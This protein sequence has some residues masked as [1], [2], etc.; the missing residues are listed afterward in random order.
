LKGGKTF[1]SKPA[2]G[3]STQ[4]KLRAAIKSIVNEHKVEEEFFH[5]LLQRLFIERP[6]NCDPPGPTFTK[7]KWTRKTLP[8]GA[9]IERWFMAFS[10][11]YGWMGASYNKCIDGK[12]FN[13]VDELNDFARWRI[14]TI[15]SSYR[16]NHPFCEHP[17][18]RERTEH[19]HH[20][21]PM[22]VIVSDAIAILSEEDLKKCLELYDRFSPD[23]YSLPDDH[24]FTSLILDRHGQ[25]SLMAL[26]IDHHYEIEGK[27]RRK[28]R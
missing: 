3:L 25:G 22:K 15:V 5:P 17:E 16:N 2:L 1:M 28:P 26:C 4:G 19:I 12:K 11:E 8:N 20:V 14:M 9:I 6:S 10:E 7:F 24:K 21:T 13:I 27:T 23:R 18:C